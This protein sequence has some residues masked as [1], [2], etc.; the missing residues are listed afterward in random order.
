[1]VE[2]KQNNATPTGEFPVITWLD[3]VWDIRTHPDGYWTAV[4]NLSKQGKEAL[5]N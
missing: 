4:S 1:M 2:T 5:E 3:M